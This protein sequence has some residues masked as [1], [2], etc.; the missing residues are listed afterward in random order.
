MEQ[1]ISNLYYSPIGYFKG[2]TAVTK[3][4]KRLPHYTKQDIQHWL[5]RQPVYQIY[6][7][8]PK[9]IKHRHYDQD[10]PNH[11]HQVDLLYLPTDKKYKYALTVIDIASRYKEAQPLK[12]KT[13]RDTA[14]AISEIYERSPLEFPSVIMCD[15]G[16]EF[17]SEFIKLMKQHNVKINRSLNKKHVAFVERFNRTLSE[18]LFA[19]Q[20]DQEIR[21]KQTRNTEWVDRLPQVIEAINNEETRMIDMKPIDAIKEESVTQPQYEDE[22]LPDEIEDFPRVRYLYKP[23]EAEGDNRYR[24]TDPIWSVD[25]YEIEEINEDEDPYVYK[26]H[27]LPDR[28][29]NV[30][31]LQVVPDDTAES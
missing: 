13:A 31:E 19:Y 9:T 30:K 28:S 27:G 12:T 10:K 14:K 11:T 23:G 17:M 21:D 22:D 20:Y 18:R 8:A 15:K 4:H 25:I 5:D 24:A 2:K 1:E 16:S 26:L 3:I 29:F 6:K 7:P